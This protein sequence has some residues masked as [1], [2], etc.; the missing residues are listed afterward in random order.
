L[1]QLEDDVPFTL[2]TILHPEV[3][4]QDLEI[5]QSLD[6][7]VHHDPV[8]IRMMEVFQQVDSKSFISH[9][10]VLITVEIP[11]SKS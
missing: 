4:L 1:V 7:R 3:V 8:E 11:W 6:I 10:F 5:D 2:P 9:A